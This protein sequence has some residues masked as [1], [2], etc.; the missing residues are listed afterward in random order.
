MVEM[1]AVRYILDEEHHELAAKDGDP[2]KYIFGQMGPLNVVIGYLPQGS[3]GIGAAATVATH[4][5]RSFPS[6]GLRLLVGIGGGIPTVAND[7]RL[8]DVVIG[9]PDGAHGGVVQYDLGK[10]TVTDFVRKGHLDNTPQEW[11]NAIVKLESDHLVVDNKILTF[12]SML[13]DRSAKL[14]QAYKMPEAERDIRSPTNK[15]HMSGCETCTHCEPA[16]PVLKSKRDSDIP[17]IFYGTIA[18]GDRVIKSAEK[19]DLISKDLGGAL[20]FEMEAAGLVNDFPCIVVRGIADY[21]DSHKNDDWHGYAAATA[22]G[23]AKELLTYMKAVAG[24]L[25]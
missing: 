2:N 8:G 19:R 23:C 17:A 7:V 15:T 4:M 1:N 6:A 24:K 21:A 16:S 14:S 20:C 11:R 5:K 9:M 22:A 10:E 13:R 12:V 3:Q 25:D 18:S